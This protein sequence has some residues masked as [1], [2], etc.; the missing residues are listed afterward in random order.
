MIIIN[1]TVSYSEEFLI[2]VNW[3]ELSFIQI[4]GS[5]GNL[6]FGVLEWSCSSAP[7]QIFLDPLKGLTA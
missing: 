7:N 6:S 4:W 2:N 3:M 1:S 5:K